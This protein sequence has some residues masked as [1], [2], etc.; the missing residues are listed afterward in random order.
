MYSR[1]LAVAQRALRRSPRSARR[2]KRG[3]RIL[4]DYLA[5]EGLLDKENH[6]YRLTPDSAAL[7]DERSPQYMGGMLQFLNAPQFWEAAIQLTE[8]VRQGRKQ[9]CWA[10]A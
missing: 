10:R 8:T 1:Q 6:E 3:M 7:L 5:I 9:L 4:C 2:R